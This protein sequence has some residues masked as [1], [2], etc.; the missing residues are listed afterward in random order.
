M[1]S[2]TMDTE[3]EPNL[4]EGSAPHQPLNGTR[5]WDDSSSMQLALV[6][7]ATANTTSGAIK[8]SRSGLSLDAQKTKIQKQVVAINE[9][10]RDRPAFIEELTLQIKAAD[11]E[12]KSLEKTLEGEGGNKQTRKTLESRLRDTK[13][14]KT[15]AEKKRQR[16]NEA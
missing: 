7:K 9:R 10:K 3:V 5:D 12:I 4:G 8:R 14:Q 16:A 2:K 15:G 11:M 13:K 1:G 6:N